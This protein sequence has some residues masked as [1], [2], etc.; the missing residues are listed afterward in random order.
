MQLSIESSRLIFQISR[1][2]FMKMNISQHLCS[3]H[4]L[5]SN[6]VSKF[7]NFIFS[8]AHVFIFKKNFFSHFLCGYFYTIYPGFQLLQFRPIL[9]ILS[10]GHKIRGFF[11]TYTR[12]RLVAIK[13]GMKNALEPSMLLTWERYHSVRFSN[14][15]SV[16]TA[17]TVLVF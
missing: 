2:E 9:H 13:S 10:C 7:S 16:Q 17:C 11:R 4:P 3:P 5:F 15:L 6:D 8:W 12:L 1:I 14:R